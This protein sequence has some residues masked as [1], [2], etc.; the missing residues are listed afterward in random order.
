MYIIVK[1]VIIAAAISLFV[2]TAWQNF[3]PSGRLSARYEFDEISP[4]ITSLLPGGRALPIIRDATGTPYQGMIGEP[5]YFRLRLPR[6]FDRVELEIRF[7]NQS[8]PILEVG[9]LAARNPDVYD[10]RPLEN[11]ILDAL[12]WSEI[13]R[14]GLTLYQ[15]TPTF[16]HIDT[17]FAQLPPRNEIATYHARVETPFRIPGYTPDERVQIIDRSLRGSHIFY[18]YVKNE[19]LDVTFY[20]QDMNRDAGGDPVA[21]NVFSDTMPVA[22]IGESDDGRIGEREEAG[23]T[24]PIHLVVPGLPEGAYRIE[25]RTTRDIFIR[26]IETRSKKFVILNE[27]F[28]GDEAG[29]QS[30][31]RPATV[32][33]SGR[34]IRASTLH[35]DGA[36]E[37]MVG[38]EVLR[39]PESHQE[40]KRRV[41]GGT[42]TRLLSPQGDVMVRTNGYFAFSRDALFV[43]EPVRLA[44]DTDLDLEGINYILARY[45]PPVR[46][47]DWKLASA[48]FDLTKLLWEDHAVPFAIS[49]PGI[50]ELQNEV[51]IG[52]I[53][54]QLE[55]EPQDIGALL[56]TLWQKLVRQ[57]PQ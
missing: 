41:S 19:S 15:R 43:P 27:L 6:R 48:E 10:L 31:D 12:D 4:F 8:Q 7:Q 44:W 50:L 13:Y 28:L 54:A 1:V 46:H 20:V 47:G 57:L 16:E 45:R 24:H 5:V 38:E 36:Q 49:A 35:A 42:P 14:D 23:E 9:G 25:I 53:A 21:I 30:D 34:L 51:R 3:A 55:R 29:Y 11:Q 32:W 39:I 40:Y 33:T 2:W 17:F 56:K 18:A 26:K 37:L 52:A 22:S